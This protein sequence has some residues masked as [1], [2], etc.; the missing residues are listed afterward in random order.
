MSDASTCPVHAGPK[1]TTNKDWWPNQLDL[2]ILQQSHPGADPMGAD[3]DYA[4]EFQSLDLDAVKK[5]IE[6]VMTT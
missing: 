1:A 3:F 6:S 4:Q 2:K 5:D